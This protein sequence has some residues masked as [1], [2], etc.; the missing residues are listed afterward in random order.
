L[1]VDQVHRHVDHGDQ[2]E[3]DRRYREPHTAA[4]A[5]AR[6]APELVEVGRVVA[7]HEEDQQGEPDPAEEDGAAVEELL[8]D[9]LDE[10]QRR[11][12]GGDGERNAVGVDRHH[13]SREHAVGVVRS[14]AGPQVGDEG[15]QRAAQGEVHEDHVQKE[16][17][18][19]Q[20]LEQPRGT[21]DA[22][23]VEGRDQV[24]VH[25]SPPRRAVR[26]TASSSPSNEAR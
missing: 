7:A 10:E 15:E 16:R 4:G 2:Q 9:H 14:A 19:Q 17:E 20:H 6:R 25:H 12:A 13:S 11:D 21:G 8:V 5:A 23:G 22:G 26:T 24:G 3:R 18:H 1:G